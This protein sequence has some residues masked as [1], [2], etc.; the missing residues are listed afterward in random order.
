M[1]Q[2]ISQWLQ[3][4][5]SVSEREVSTS[6]KLQTEKPQLTKFRSVAWVNTFILVEVL[7]EEA[8]ALEDS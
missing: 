7:N 2:M 5:A 6:K 3:S 8:V 4:T 1:R